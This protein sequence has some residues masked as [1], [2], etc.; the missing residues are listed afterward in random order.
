M[1]ITSNSTITYFQ[2]TNYKQQPKITE[3]HSVPISF[4]SKKCYNLYGYPSLKYLYAKK[5]LDDEIEKQNSSNLN[6][7]NIDL[8]KIDGIQDGI[9]VFNKMN[10]KEIAFVAQTIGSIAVSR[11]CHNMCSHCYADAIPPIKEDNEHINKMSWED[12][13]AITNGFETLHKRIGSKITG[14]FFDRDPYMAPFHD[15]DCIDLC[16]KDK[17]GNE[18]DF[19]E[20]SEKLNSAFQ[21]PVLFDTAGWSPKNKKAQQRA[22]KYAEYYSK[23]ENMKNITAFNVSVNPYHALNTRRVILEKEGNF[24]KA[25]KF[26]DLYTTRMAN[27]LFTL[28]PLLK[29]DKFEFITRA[30]HNNTKGTDGFKEKDLQELYKD[31]FKKLEKRYNDDLNGEQK[32]IHYPGQINNKI[33]QYKTKMTEVDT[34]LSVSGRLSKIYPTDD[35]MTKESKFIIDESIQHITNSTSVLDLVEPRRVFYPNSVGSYNSTY[36]GILDANGKYYLT[37]SYSTFPTEIQLNLDNSNKKTAPIHPNLQQDTT[38]K[39]SLINTVFD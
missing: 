8:N 36:K 2:S 11:G 26:K 32:F 34:S 7:Y 24:E 12:F 23:A 33:A 18:H 6:I 35:Y 10:M 38:I 4:G 27:V 25:E 19:I 3:N 31:I 15:A 13:E 5:N 37:N 21:L 30:A 14:N 20:I 9:K 1:R 28:T 22:E 29:S 39:K 16:L 17:N